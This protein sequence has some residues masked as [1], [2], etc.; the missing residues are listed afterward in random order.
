MAF[1]LFPQTDFRQMDLNYVL[2]VSKQAAAN[3]E[4]YAA[5]KEQVIATQAAAE[6][7]LAAA[8]QDIETAT[9]AAT[10]ASQDAQTASGAA[11]T[12]TQAA[13]SAEQDAQT[14]SSAA[15]RAEQVKESIPAD[16]TNLSNQV[17]ELKSDL[18]YTFS[19]DNGANVSVF[20]LGVYNSTDGGFVNRSAYA[21]CLDVDTGGYPC[22]IKTPNKVRV[23]IRDADGTYGTQ[24]NGTY[25][26]ELP[27]G[28]STHVLLEISDPARDWGYSYTNEEIAPLANGLRF[29]NG[30]V[31]TIITPPTKPQTTNDG[32]TF[33]SWVLGQ[34]ATYKIVLN[35]LDCIKIFIPS[36][37][38]SIPVLYTYENN[39][40]TPIYSEQWT[41]Q[42]KTFC[43]SKKM[44]IYAQIR[45]YVNNTHLNP[46]IFYAEKKYK[47]KFKL[48]GINMCCI[49]DSY[50]ANNGVN[51]KQT[52]A[53]KIAT[54]YSMNYTNLGISGGGICATRGD[55]LPITQRYTQIPLDSD[56]I[57]LEGG[58]ND[59]NAE[60]DITAF[61]S[62]FTTLIENIKAQNYGAALI[63]MCPWGDAY[64]NRTR[65][66][67]YAD[68]MRNVSQKYGVPFFDSWIKYVYNA[69]STARSLFYQSATDHA[70]LNNNGHN[71]FMPM[72]ESFIQSVF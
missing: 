66:K 70:H 52:W 49:G 12:A 53:D 42:Y 54:K 6:R 29:C 19:L 35:A 9:Q 64:A 22:Y 26:I 50:I 57:I 55:I 40:F 30:E 39:V 14:A 15:E 36:S 20:G 46:P 56:L 63:V 31:N 48:Y 23:I 65:F 43:A 7:A 51:V 62:E 4:E 60:Y 5:D 67:P 27:Y 2:E 72:I 13:A 58:E 1:N 32:T 34:W 10:S 3:L 41:N 68:A 69:T 18:G 28:S 38:A 71:V 45:V 33:T 47:E 11:G 17:S 8:Q 61:E 37:S 25:L 59:A 21:W 16:Y 24:I 44:T